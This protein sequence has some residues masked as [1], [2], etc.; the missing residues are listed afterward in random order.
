MSDLVY[1]LKTFFLRI[2]KLAGIFDL[3]VYNFM[4]KPEIY[5]KKLITLIKY[6]W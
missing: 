3:S 6:F 2:L 1:N 5:V 4:R